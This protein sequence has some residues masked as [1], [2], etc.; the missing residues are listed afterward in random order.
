MV[1]F[2]SEVGKNEVVEGGIYHFDNKSFI[3]K[4]WTADME[5][6]RDELYTIS[7][8]IGLPGLDFKYLEP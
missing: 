2:D 6:R 8:K 5:F 4:A 7:I 3:V 1:R